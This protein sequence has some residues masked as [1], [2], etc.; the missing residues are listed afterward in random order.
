VTSPC[1]ES[2]TPG[3]KDGE[4]SD[5]LNAGERGVVCQGSIKSPGRSDFLFGTASSSE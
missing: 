3:E 4:G 2:I 1:Q 5:A